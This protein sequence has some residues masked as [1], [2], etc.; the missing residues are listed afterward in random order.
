MNNDRS[1]GGILPEE[2]QVPFYTFGSAFSLADAA[3]RQTDICGTVCQLL[4]VA[5]DKSVCTELLA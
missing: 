3:I 1:H 5:H 4:G 2:R